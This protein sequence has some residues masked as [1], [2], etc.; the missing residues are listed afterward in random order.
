M[1]ELQ[2]LVMRL[3]MTLPEKFLADVERAIEL[4]IEY[5]K[6]LAQA[7]APTPGADTSTQPNPE[8]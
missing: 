4:A 7:P 8:R 2:G 1:T 6:E 5:G 3:G